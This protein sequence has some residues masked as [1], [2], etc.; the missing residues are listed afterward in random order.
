MTMMANS[1]SLGGGTV[2]D[3]QWPMVLGA[4]RDG[5][6]RARALE[7]L[8]TSYWRP[9]YCFLRRRGNSSHDSEDLTQGFFVHITGGDFLDRP[10]PSKGRFRGFLLSALRQY[11]GSHFE[12]ENARKRGGGAR[13]IAW[14]SADAEAEYGSLE[15]T[16]RDPADIF[17][18]SWALSLLG[19]ALARLRDEQAAAGKRAS[20]EALSPF[21]SATPTRGDYERVGRLL[22][23]SRTTVAVWV[24]RLN[25]RYA[26]LVRLEV[27]STVQDPSEIP[28]EM[29]HLL[30][31]LRAR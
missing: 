5:P 29:Q 1:G 22:G 15:A 26:E 9:I 3:T 28:A 18:T 4:R 31:A 7:E 10:D 14:D 27:A 25:H 2:E 11:L 6:E 12:R 13:F 17:E 20:F 21:I 8:C 19:R 23:A 16:H 30:E 24:H